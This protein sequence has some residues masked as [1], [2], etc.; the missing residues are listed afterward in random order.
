MYDERKRI[1][2]TR[3]F[4]VYQRLYFLLNYDLHRGGTQ[5]PLT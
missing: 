1:Q 5:G 2:S 4:L 3:H